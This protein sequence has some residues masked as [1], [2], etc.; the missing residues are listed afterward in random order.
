[1]IAKA[2]IAGSAGP[3]LL[4]DERRFFADE[5]PFGFILFRRNCREPSEVE[6]LVAAFRDAAG[7]H[8]PV[9]IDQEGGRV[10][11]LQPPHWPLFPPARRYGELAEKDEEVGVRAAWLGARLIADQLV[12]LG[13]DVDC[14]PLLDVPSPDGHDIIGDRAYGTSPDLV[15]LLARAACEGLLAGGVLPIVKH[16]PG[17]GRAGADSHKELP[18]VSVDADRLAKTDFLPFQKLADMPI[19][20]TAH[21]V[22]SAIDASA[23]A[24]TSPR[25]VEEVIRGL[26]GFDGLLVSDD[27]GMSAL[28]GSFSRRA[29]ETLDAGADI[30]LHCSGDFGEMREV[31]SAV[32]E[33]TGR[34]KERATAALARRQT[35]QALD[36]EAAWRE[37]EELMNGVGW[38]PR[39]V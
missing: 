18:V 19:A 22:Y 15:S 27:L 11:R 2:F 36:R 3:R 12:P 26:I 30:A 29:G 24:S 31:A 8:A 28:S 32:P 39:Q 34:T 13:I 9:L 21:V 35:P 38:P 16:I 17:H 37:F 4:P 23:P 6:D 33:L 1:M 5:R 25:V 14:Y 20:M 7:S 10:A